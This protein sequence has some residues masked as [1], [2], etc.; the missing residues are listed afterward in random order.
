MSKLNWL[1][2]RRS[3]A[4]AV[5][6]LTASFAFVASASAQDSGAAPAAD[7]KKKEVSSW[8]KLCEKAQIKKD[9]AK[10]EVCITHHERLD[11]NSG[12]VVV[13]AAVRKIE[14][15]DKQRFLVTVPL[16]MALPPGMGASID[17]SKNI[18]LLK[19][20]F[21][22][23]NG[24]TAETE[25]TDELMAQMVGGKMITV[26]AI[27][28]LGERIGFQVPLNGF[29]PTYDGPAI[30][31]QKFA[32]ARK[33]LLDRIREKQIE[34]AKAAKDGAAAAPADGAAA[35]ADAAPAQ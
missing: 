23:P 31:T 14:G 12:A 8:V 32:Q 33:S 21:C 34:R 26:Q 20:T 2:G 3:G 16:G 9:A 25:V 19:Y 22:L 10:Q 15:Q 29:K 24:C 6:A 30:D 18:I 28:A 13:S 11:P 17:G 5:V 7:G 27:N 35:P 1:N 4:L